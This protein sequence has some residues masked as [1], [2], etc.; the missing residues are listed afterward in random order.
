[1][2]GLIGVIF[3]ILGFF[4]VGL[5][6]IPLGLLCTAISMVSKRGFLLGIISLMMNT[7]AIVVS[8]SVWVVIAG[9]IGSNINTPTQVKTSI[10]QSES[11]KNW[12]VKNVNLSASRDSDIYP[13]SAKKLKPIELG[14]AILMLMPP[15]NMDS[16]NWTYQQ[17]SPDIVWTDKGFKSNQGSNNIYN[18]KNGL[19]RI[20]VNGEKSTIFKN[21]DLELAWSIVL[22]KFGDPANGPET[23]EIEPGIEDGDANC[24]GS[25]T[26]NCAFN[27]L[28]SLFMANIKIKEICENKTLIQESI[29]GYLLQAKGKRSI[30]LLW[31]TGYGSGGS[32]S[33]ITLFIDSGYDKTDIC[34]I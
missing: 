32:S 12:D 26:N 19:M 25:D 17:N 10:E 29:K 23:I 1:M 28:E 18:S 16:V 13:L 33:T 30:R 5:V 14:Q 20:T 7:A 4:S 27:P 6:F 9:I 31:E 11:I 22:Q 21:K 3:G 15:V 34:N 24:F 2:F 8:P